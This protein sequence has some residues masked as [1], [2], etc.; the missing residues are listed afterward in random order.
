MNFKKEEMSVDM[1][2]MKNYVNDTAIMLAS[3]WQAINH[4]ASESDRLEAIQTLL[5]YSFT[6]ILQESSNSIVNMVI[7]QALPNVNAAQQRYDYQCGKKTSESNNSGGRPR[8]IDYEEIM[9]YRACGYSY[10]T[11]GKMTGINISTLKSIVRRENI[12]SLSSQESGCKPDGLQP[13]NKNNEKEKNNNKEIETNIKVEVDDAAKIERK[14]DFEKLACSNSLQNF[15]GSNSSLNDRIQSKI[16]SLAT[17]YKEYGISADDIKERFG[18]YEDLSAE[19]AHMYFKKL[20]LFENRM[21]AQQTP[22]VPLDD[23]DVPF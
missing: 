5:N 14:L 3:T 15:D 9:R 1:T 10:G 20:C 21:R 4:I 19:D 16:V 11:I 2:D 22:I 13:L 12:S 8:E 17:E 18:N 7:A 23:S 6:G